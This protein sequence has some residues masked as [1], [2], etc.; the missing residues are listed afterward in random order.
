MDEASF[1]AKLKAIGCEELITVDWAP[2]HASKEHT[3][4]FTAYG[5]IV[6]GAFT[7]TTPSGPQ[8]L[9]VGDTFELAPGIP[10]TETVNEEGAQVLAAKVMH[11]LAAA[12]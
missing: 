9:R 8:R 11:K 7:L 6:R 12:G 3:H 10:H 1:R 2:G 4:E 5:L